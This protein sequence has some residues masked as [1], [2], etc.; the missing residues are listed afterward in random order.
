MGEHDTYKVSTGKINQ[1]SKKKRR[2]Q[3]ISF[4]RVQPLTVFSM[5]QTP[6]LIL[7]PSPQPS[8]RLA[9]PSPSPPLLS[10]ERT[11]YYGSKGNVCFLDIYYTTQD[12]NLIRRL[13]PL[14]GRGRAN[15]RAAEARSPKGCVIRRLLSPFLSSS[16][17]KN[18]E[19]KTLGL[20]DS[21]LYTYGASKY[22]LKCSWLDNSQK[23]S[24][25]G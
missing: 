17:L 25:L 3:N 24:V 9:I 5:T 12:W 10:A 11:D 8:L 19:K 20:F 6:I 15:C 14:W 13:E 22:T 1:I 2:H 23:K 7:S 4:P 18:R 16:I 21:V